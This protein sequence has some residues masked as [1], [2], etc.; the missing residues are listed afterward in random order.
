MF[1]HSGQ[2]EYRLSVSEVSHSRATVFDRKALKDSALHNKATWEVEVCVVA[3][4]VDSPS[5]KA[6]NVFKIPFFEEAPVRYLALPSN[7]CATISHF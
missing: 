4:L 3:S 5:V 7:L 6:Q 1:I 2:Y